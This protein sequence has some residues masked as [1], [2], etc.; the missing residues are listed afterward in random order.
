MRLALAGTGQMGQAVEALARERGHEVVARF[1]SD[2]PLAAADRAALNGAEVVVDF[3]LPGVVLDH[4]AQY[5]RWN[6][7]A[8][9]GTTGWAEG[10]DRVREQVAQSETALLYAPNFSLGVA[11]LVRALRSVTPLL[12]QLPEYDVYVHEV[13]HTRKVDSPSGTALLLG[14]VLLDGLSRKTHIEPETQHERID[15][16]ALHVSATRAGHVVGHH[17]V[18]MDSLFD[19]LTFTHEAKSRQGFAFGAVRAAEWLPGRQGLFTLDD[20]LADWLGED[21]R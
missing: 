12:E 9:I 11:L 21:A 16:A 7:P 19:R 17:T 14:G 18:G 8:V 1:N 10:L 5:C 15:A 4:I 3:S 13:H 20:L 6:Q 2:H